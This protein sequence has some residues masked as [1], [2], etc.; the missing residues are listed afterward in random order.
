MF[1][2]SATTARPYVSVV[3]PTKNRYAT[4]IPVVKAFVAAI[5]DPGLQ[6]VIQDN[7]PDNDEVV[8]FLEALGDA[9]IVYAHVTAPLSIV[10]NTEA[11]LDRATGDYVTFIGD[12]DLVSPF[13]VDVARALADTNIE[14]VTYPSA[15]Y[16]WPSVKFANPSPFH[17]PGAFWYPSHVGG[18]ARR[19]EP[20][21]ELSRVLQSGAVS[22]FDLPRLYHGLVRRDVLLRLRQSTGRYVNGASPDM[23]LAVG[24]GLTVRHHVILDYPL[25]IYG[26]SKHSGGGWT[27]ERKHFGRIENQTHLPR[28]TIDNWS[29]KLPRIWSEYTIYPQTVG[30]VLSAMSLP[31]TINYT[32]FYAAMAVN[33]PQFRSM[34]TPLLLAHLRKQPHQ[35]SRFVLTLARKIFGRARRALNRHVF[36]MPYRLEIFQSPMDCMAYL[37]SI[38]RPRI[39]VEEQATLSQ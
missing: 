22:M 4:L 19:L 29:S 36:G 25:T 31:D 20:A 24:L 18:H 30:E 15:Y 34:L 10:E 2:E 27:A 26:A 6:L 38:P 13:I 3:I 23:A 28:S 33:E 37:C 9:R 12:D 7:T 17:Q 14:A 8:S 21:A 11:A 39:C 35:A 1:E 5:P 16:W 32:A